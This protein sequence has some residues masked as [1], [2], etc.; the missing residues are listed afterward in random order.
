MVL[1]PHAQVLLVW[2]LA[3]FLGVTFGGHKQ[4]VHSQC[5]LYHVFLHSDNL[6]HFWDHPVQ[7]AETRLLLRHVEYSW[8]LL[9]YILHAALLN[10]DVQPIHKWY[11]LWDH[12]ARNSAILVLLQGFVFRQNLWLC[13]FH[14]HFIDEHLLWSHVLRALFDVYSDWIR[15][16]QC[17]FPCGLRRSF[18]RPAREWP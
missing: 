12:A 7:R 11:P 16:D 15:Q 9:I 18:Q 6:L 3:A 10:Q 1:G 2:V 13:C 4:Q 8:H 17:Y 5:H 14:P